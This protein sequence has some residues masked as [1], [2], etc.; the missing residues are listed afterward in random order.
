MALVMERY[1]MQ[2]GEEVALKCSGP[3]RDESIAPPLTSSCPRSRI[4]SR[5]AELRA[6][7]LP[8]AQNQ[9]A[10]QC[11]EGLHNRL[12]DSAVEA[13]VDVSAFSVDLIACVDSVGS[14]QRRDLSRLACQPWKAAAMM[15]CRD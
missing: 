10:H 13:R 14:L 8:Y 2:S 7:T 3:H 15:C 11:V 5:G 6:L 1:G 9:D 12:H 4:V